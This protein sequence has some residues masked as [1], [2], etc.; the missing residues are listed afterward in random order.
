MA[1]KAK[2]FLLI[3][4]IALYGLMVSCSNDMWDPEKNRKNGEKFLKENA[5]KEGV[6][7]TSSGLQYKILV[8]GEGKKPA[9]S[10]TVKCYYTGTFINGDKFDGTSSGKPATFKVNGVIKG[11]QQALKLMPVGSK[12]EI[13]LPYELGYGAQGVGNDIPPYSALIFEIELI[14]IV[15]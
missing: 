2:S 5:K 4:S 6:V 13:Y 7:V 9:S 11:W 15:K 3:I 1:T 14:E 8:E 10:N 12:W